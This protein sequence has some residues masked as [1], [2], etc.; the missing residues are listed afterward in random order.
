MGFDELSQ[1]KEAF[2]RGKG[3]RSDFG[4]RSVGLHQSILVPT[5]DTSNDDAQRTV[6]QESCISFWRAVARSWALA[7]GCCKTSILQFSGWKPSNFVERSLDGV[8]LS[9]RLDRQLGNAPSVPGARGSPARVDQYCSHSTHS[10]GP[11]IQCEPDRI[12]CF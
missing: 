11:A 5:M 9:C 4:R 12:P 10:R 1:W 3:L 8:G 7:K 2:G 6:P